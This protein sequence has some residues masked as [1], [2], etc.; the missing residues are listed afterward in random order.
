[1]FQIWI[2]RNSYSLSLMFRI[3]LSYYIQYNNLEI[4]C[5][6]LRNS[7]HYFYLCFLAISY[8]ILRYK[9]GTI[10]DCRC[11]YKIHRYIFVQLM[12]SHNICIEH[13]LERSNRPFHTENWH[14]IFCVRIV[15]PIHIITLRRWRPRLLSFSYNS[16]K[17]ISW[18]TLMNDVFFFSNQLILKS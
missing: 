8:S 9:A 13:F 5:C 11:T 6:L 1:M 2:H 12:T 3:F 16:L 17:T 18:L 14:R 7:F 10:L 15:S 4:D